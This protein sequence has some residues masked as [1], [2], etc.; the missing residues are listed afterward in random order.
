MVRGISSVSIPTLSYISDNGGKMSLPVDSSHLIY[1]HFKHV[2]GIPA[3]EGIQG[4]SISKLNLLDVL[5]GQLDGLK[6]KSNFQTTVNPFQ[7]IDNLIENFGNQIRQ[8][9]IAS[10][11]MPYNP[12]PNAQNGILFNLT[13]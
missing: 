9:K 5:L 10:A 7:G 4:V 12:S 6:K 13:S 2:S 1:S 8:A 3:Q 11:A